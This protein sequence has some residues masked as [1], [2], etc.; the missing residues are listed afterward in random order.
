[1]RLYRPY[2]APPS[3]STPA[4]RVSAQVKS[5]AQITLSSVRKVAPDRHLIKT[6]S[7]TLE[8]DDVSSTVRKA[9]ALAKEKGGYVFGLTEEVEPTGEHSAI[10][11]IRVP[12]DEFENTLLAIERLGK[13][14]S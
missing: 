8:T 13:V 1:M 11:E 9:I 5:P 12:A 2:A 4:T 3:I 10:L 6:A 7:V 14:R